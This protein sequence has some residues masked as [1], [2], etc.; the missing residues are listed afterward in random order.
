MLVFRQLL[1]PSSSTY[2]YLLGDSHSGEAVII[3][4]V[5]EQARRDTALLRELGATVTAS[6]AA[7]DHPALNLID[8]D[9]GTS[10]RSAVVNARRTSPG[11]A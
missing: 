2:S 1:D 11:R 6:S 8:G 3:D 7:P 10:W 5:F 9:P 4:P